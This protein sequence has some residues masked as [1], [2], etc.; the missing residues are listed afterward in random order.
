MKKIFPIFFAVLALCSCSKNDFKVWKSVNAELITRVQTDSADVY[1]T[2]PSG[3]LYRKLA[4]TYH[5][6]Y[7]PKPTSYVCVNYKGW[8]VDG[9][10][11]DSGSKEWLYVGNLVS[12]WQEILCMMQDGDRW[13]IYIPYSLGYGSDGTTDDDG[14]F[15]IPPYS[16]LI[17]DLEIVGDGVIN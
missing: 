13:R 17:F 3:V 15:I 4:P 11:F 14:N 12:G 6:G 16:T 9:T 8:L 2:S 7:K 5:T 10:E 1:K